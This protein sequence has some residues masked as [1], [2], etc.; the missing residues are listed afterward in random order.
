M[1][2]KPVLCR[3]APLIWSAELLQDPGSAIIAAARLRLFYVF[4]PFDQNIVVVIDT[5]PVVG[6]PDQ[7]REPTH[8][9]KA[10]GSPDR[11]IPR[12]RHLYADS[13]RR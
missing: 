11:F 1:G 3:V 13:D 10:R 12:M 6:S 7:K 9:K 4:P 5:N 8:P 2:A